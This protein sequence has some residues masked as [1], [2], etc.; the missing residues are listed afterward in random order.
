MGRWV[1]WFPNLKQT[2]AVPLRVLTLNPYTTKVGW[3]L[4]YA[5]LFLLLYVA[6]KS[7]HVCVCVCVSMGGGQERHSVVLL[8]T[9]LWTVSHWVLVAPLQSDS[10]ES[11]RHQVFRFPTQLIC[12]I[13]RC[14]LP[15]LAHLLPTVLFPACQSKIQFLIHQLSPPAPQWETPSLPVPF[16]PASLC[17][18]TKN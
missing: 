12:T 18:A 10:S 5:C 4:G 17:P 2:W 15:D 1:M 13:V 7:V 8:L 9:P 6:S 16:L 14:F 11:H 3:V